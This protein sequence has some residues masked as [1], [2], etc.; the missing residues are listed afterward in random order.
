[1]RK[2]K[3]KTRMWMGSLMLASLLGFGLYGMGSS[4]ASGGHDRDDDDEHGYGYREIPRQSVQLQAATKIYREECGSCHLAYP[5]QLLPPGSWEK[6]MGNLEDHFG[7]NA[8]LDEPTRKQLQD[9]LV[10]RST[11]RRG[12]YRRILRNMDPDRLPMR[13][14][15]MVY[16]RRKH[17][18]I[19]DR[20]IRGND[21]VRSLSQCDACHRDAERGYFDEDR[22]IVPG[23]G[24][25]DD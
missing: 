3:M 14:T 1:M 10:Q 5:P 20:L 15:D 6:V 22:V 12:E 13:I 23:V 7:E 18:E 4:L 9:Y 11:P 25:W 16:F 8:E 2:V 19:P 21:K 24:R 17:H